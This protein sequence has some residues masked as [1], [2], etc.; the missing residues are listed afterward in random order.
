[1]IREL[2]MTETIREAPNF[3]G[4]DYK[5]F[6]QE[7]RNNAQ[8]EPLGYSEHEFTVPDGEQEWIYGMWSSPNGLADHM[9]WVAKPGTYVVDGVAT[10]DRDRLYEITSLMKGRCTVVEDG[11]EPFEMVAGSTYVMRRGWKGIWT[12]HES[13]VKNVVWVY[14]V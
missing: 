3:E 14:D 1:M 5:R 13:V 11:K 7:S 12:V 2:E 10:R 6:S 9:V 8:R 4:E